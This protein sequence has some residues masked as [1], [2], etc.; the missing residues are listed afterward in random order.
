METYVFKEFF[1]ILKVS[2]RK[3]ESMIYTFHIS[4]EA[5]S[6]LKSDCSSLSNS[7]V[8]QWSGTSPFTSWYLTFPS[9]KW[10]HW[11]HRLHRTPVRQLNRIIHIQHMVQWLACS[12]LQ[13]TLWCATQMPLQEQRTTPLSLQMLEL[14]EQPSNQL[15]GDGLGWRKLFTWHHACFFPEVVHHQAI[16][17]CSGLVSLPQLGIILWKIIPAS[18]IP[19]ELAERPL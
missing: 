3:I 1:L 18:K 11:Q 7:S 13:W 12:R 4:M 19:V 2:V 17:G 5:G 6:I 14:P 16:W 8:T 15:S 9:V 10:E